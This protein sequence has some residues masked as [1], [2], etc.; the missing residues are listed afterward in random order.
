M[1]GAL[2]DDLFYTAFLAQM[3]HVRENSHVPP[4]LAEDLLMLR[5]NV[6]YVMHQQLCLMGH[7]VLQSGIGRSARWTN[8]EQMGLC[9]CGT[10]IDGQQLIAHGYYDS[11]THLSD[12]ER[13]KRGHCNRGNRGLVLRAHSGKG[14]LRYARQGVFTKADTCTHQG[15]AWTWAV[16]ASGLCIA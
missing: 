5:T 1:A 7:F 6:W 2:A 15:E 3:R 11:A 9:T 13:L 4:G 12:I 10:T 8:R 14:L 16:S